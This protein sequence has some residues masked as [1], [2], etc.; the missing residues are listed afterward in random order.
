MHVAAAT[1]KPRYVLANNSDLNIFEKQP[2]LDP[3]IILSQDFGLDLSENILVKQAMLNVLYNII[4]D[5]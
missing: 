1:S 5:M 3:L 2:S 4:L